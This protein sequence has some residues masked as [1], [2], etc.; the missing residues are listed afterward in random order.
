MAANPTVQTLELCISIF[1]WGGMQ[2]G[3][4]RRLFNNS[5]EPWVLIADQIRNRRLSR[6]QAYAAFAK[7]RTIKNAMSGLGPAYFTKLI[8]FLSPTRSVTEAG[9]FVYGR[10]A[11]S[12]ADAPATLAVNASTVRTSFFMKIRQPVG[13][14]LTPIAASETLDFT[15]TGAAK[16]D[17]AAFPHGRCPKVFQRQGLVLAFCDLG[18]CPVFRC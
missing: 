9:A 6:A 14:T 15:A 13:V 12:A 5:V 18:R 10:A 11:K 17:N 3:H 8:Y 2:A 4:A 7:L 1:T 16:R